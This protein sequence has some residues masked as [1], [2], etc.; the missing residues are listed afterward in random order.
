MIAIDIDG[1]IAES[2]PWLRKE[3]EERTGITLKFNSP[4]TYN[5]GT[6]IKDS[7]CKDYIKDA[8]IKYKDCI[9]V[10]DRINTIK[11]LSKL[12]KKYGVI[13]FVTARENGA[14]SESTHYWL[15]RNF[16]T[17]LCYN[18]HSLGEH[19][20]KHLWMWKNDINI[21]IEDRLKTVNAIE[22][23]HMVPY[24]INR[25]WNI[26]R[27]TKDHVIRVNSLLEAVDHHLNEK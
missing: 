25:E 1:V 3:I 8:L 18:L 14:V 16:G 21:I 15:K 6:N 24:L 12:Q 26:G 20:D 4:R 17:G 23:P 10:Y 22:P 19:A 5:F 27:F 9:A 2:D 13:H 11:A 7:D